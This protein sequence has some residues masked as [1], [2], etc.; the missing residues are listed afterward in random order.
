MTL[1]SLRSAKCSGLS[2]GERLYRV[3]FEQIAVY[4]RTG[5]VGTHVRNKTARFSYIGV[6]FH[7]RIW[8][9]QSSLVNRNLTKE[10]DYMGKAILAA[11]VTLIVGYLGTVVGLE[12]LG[13]WDEF[14]LLIAIAVMGA[15]IIY[16]NDK[17]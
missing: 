3:R 7:W 1:S 15:F 4:V 6:F 17:K 11:I 16:F 8:Y 2:E 5:E 9:T 12:L 10:C 14:G 13:N